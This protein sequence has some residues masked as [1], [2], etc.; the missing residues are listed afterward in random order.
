MDGVLVV[1]KPKGLT[2]HDV[3][4]RVRRALGTKR[5]G[6]VG[7]LDPMATGVLPL[8]IGRATRLATL[9]SV[10]PKIYAAVIR[11]G[12]VTDT[13]DAT[14]SVISSAPGETPTVDIT[15]DA[16]EAASRRFVGTFHQQPPPFSAKK[17]RGVRAYRLARRRR[18]VPLSPVEITVHK[19]EIQ[20]LEL[21]QLYCRVS[22]SPGF[23]MRALAHDLGQTLGCGACLESLRREQSGP[24]TP[25][26]AVSL[27]E[28]GDRF[29]L[30]E[31]SLI[32]IGNLL[33]ELPTVVVTESGSKRVLHGNV[34]THAHI[35]IPP[36]PSSLI[37]TKPAEVNKV[38]VYDQSG[39][40]LAIAETGPGD[41]L[42]PRIVL[43]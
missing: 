7:T 18:P 16:I 10:G 23:Y 13:Y 19:F 43:V 6:H 30:T 15:L 27:T 33:P 26:Q 31:H 3:V 40:L 2:S 5:V 39:T 25:D 36:F 42:H 4:S 41:T 34:I 35:K 20:S 8:V 14:G 32:S 38:K 28:L 1:D 29:G 21:D 24:F 11:L 9:L 22:C 37:G 17:I 12:M